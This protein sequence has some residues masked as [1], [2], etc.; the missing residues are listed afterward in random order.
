METNDETE[1]PVRKRRRREVDLGPEPVSNADVW[2]AY[3]VCEVMTTFLQS[4]LYVAFVGARQHVRA[5][6]AVSS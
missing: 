1:A 2:K 6:E 3:P 4:V 5:P